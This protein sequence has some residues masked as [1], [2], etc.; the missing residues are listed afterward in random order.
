MSQRCEIVKIYYD[1]FGD[2]QEVEVD[3]IG[4]KFTAN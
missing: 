3:V 1:E 2:D 4:Q